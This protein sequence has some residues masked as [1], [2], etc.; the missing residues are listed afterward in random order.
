M[1]KS[2]KVSQVGVMRNRFLGMML[3]ALGIGA[4]IVVVRYLVIAA[5]VPMDVYLVEPSELIPGATF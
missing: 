2:V 5:Q 1:K 3:L 4:M